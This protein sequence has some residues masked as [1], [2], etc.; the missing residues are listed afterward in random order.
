MSCRV[1]NGIEV[2]AAGIGIPES[3][4]LVR[5]R[6]IPVS[7]WFR[8]RHTGTGPNGSRLSGI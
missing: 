3:G 8:H 2:N 1:G 7:D 6:K 4:I 5:Y